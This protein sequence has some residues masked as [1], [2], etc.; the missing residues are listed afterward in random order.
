MRFDCGSGGLI[1]RYLSFCSADSKA[2]VIPSVAK[3][4]GIRILTKID[5]ADK[6]QKGNCSG[7]LNFVGERSLMLGTTTGQSPGND[8]AAFGNEISQGFRIF[9]IN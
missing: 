5:R 6:R 1:N 4:Y 3:K 7:P 8:F 9:V 2:V